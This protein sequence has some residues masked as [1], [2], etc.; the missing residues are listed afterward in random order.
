MKEVSCKILWSMAK[1]QRI[2]IT[3]SKRVWATDE[4]SY[5]YIWHRLVKV[6]EETS[7]NGWG[8]NALG[9]PSL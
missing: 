4:K 7:I 5:M 3:F 2:S 8:L 9:E 1:V 6:H